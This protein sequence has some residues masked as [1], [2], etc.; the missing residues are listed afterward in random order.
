MPGLP[1]PC[2][3]KNLARN[4]SDSAPRCVYNPGSGSC[5]KNKSSSLKFL[6]NNH[7]RTYSLFASGG[8]DDLAYNLYVLWLNEQLCD[9]ELAVGKES[10]KAHKVSEPGRSAQLL[11]PSQSARRSWVRFPGRSNRKQCRQRLATAAMF[12]W[13]AALARR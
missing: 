13:S 12:F 3:K 4:S 8:K 10:I 7:V 6:G 1:S 11:S 9:V 2:E 5:S